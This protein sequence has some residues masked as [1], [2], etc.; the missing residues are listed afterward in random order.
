MVL[1]YVNIDTCNRQNLLCPVCGE[2]YPV[3][4]GDLC[5][6][7]GGETPYTEITGIET[8]L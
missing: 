7:C 6:N 1:H 4:D 8:P 5:R 3:R 2:A